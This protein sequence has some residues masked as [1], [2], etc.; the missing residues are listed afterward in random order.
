VSH[1]RKEGKYLLQS[2][3]TFSRLDRATLEFEPSASALRLLVPSEPGIPQATRLEVRNWREST[4][5]DALHKLVLVESGQIDLEGGSGGWLIIPNHLVFIPADRAFTIQSAWALL[6]VAHLDPKDA[7][8]HHHGCWATSA[9]PLAKEMMAQA[10]RWEPDQVRGEDWPRLFFRTLSHLCREWFANPRML[11]M[12]AAKSEEMRGAVVYIRDH[13]KD[14]SLEG[15]CAATGLGERTFQRRCEKELGCVWRTLLR[16]VR[17]MRAMELLSCGQHSVG[18]VADET[19]FRSLAAFTTSFSERLG[20][21][22]TEFVRRFAQ[23]SG[24]V[25]GRRRVCM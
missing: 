16:E 5:G 4:L 8:W 15:V 11:W 24:P 7:D 22:P 6:Q 23:Q 10:L 2:V 13:L 1:N 9:T 20:L 25:K 12:P 19:G 3:T 21:T 18:S 17:L 14:A